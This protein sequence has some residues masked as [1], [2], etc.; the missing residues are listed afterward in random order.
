[1]SPKISPD[2]LILVLTP[3]ELDTMRTALRNEQERY[4][5][6]GFNGLKVAVQNLRDKISN[7]M[8]DN[9]YNK[10]GATKG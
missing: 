1:M 3:S 2:D 8:I 7:A 6:Q 5:R 4:E 9:A 10:V